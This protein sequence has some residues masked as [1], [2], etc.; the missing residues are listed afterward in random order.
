MTRSEKAL[1][2]IS[3]VI[4]LLLLAFVSLIVLQ[5]VD[6]S[7]EREISGPVTIG[8]K[9]QE[10]RPA[11]ALK[12]RRRAQTVLLYPADANSIKGNDISATE[13]GLRLPDSTVVKPELIA[14][15]EDGNTFPLKHPSFQERKNARGEHVWVMG[16]SGD[17]N[18]KTDSNLPPDRTYP[19]IRIRSDKPLKLS[20]VSW[21]CW[22]PL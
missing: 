13:W 3:S 2:L 17:R 10:L 14:V 20:K 15:D 19:L 12:V 21:Y 9:W 6:T 1:A 16:L 8:P 18:Q 11:K 22:S 5:F 7:T 4:I